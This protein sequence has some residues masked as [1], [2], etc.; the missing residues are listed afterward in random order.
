MTELITTW[1]RFAE[2]TIK[3]NDLDPMYSVIYGLNRSKSRKWM[4]VF[5]MTFL[6]YYD[7]GQAAEWAD[8]SDGSK[9][10]WD[11]LIATASSTPKWMFRGTER[12]HMRG[13]NE[14]KAL[15]KLASFGVEP[16]ELLMQMYGG[17]LELHH[18]PP[19]TYTW[20]YKNMTTRFSGTQFGPYFVWKLYDIFNVC[21]GMPISLSFAEALKYMPDEPKKA[22]THFFPEYSFESA[23]L[24]VDTEIRKYDHPVVPGRK[25][26]LA[27]AETI[28][29]MMKGFFK[30]KTHEIGDDIYDKFKQL[31]GYPELTALL[32]PRV[33]GQYVRY[34]GILTKESY[35]GM[36]FGSPGSITE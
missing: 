21:L 20:L 6:L 26:G 17:D 30:T 32:P 18:F 5:I 15:E 27:E 2:V 14:R 36:G 16:W 24:A 13:E 9:D 22:A 19:V 35:E 31:T 25:C 23:L 3:T 11:A 29:C 33:M 1:Q 28:L 7:A 34:E 12:R 10:Y 4:G 8:R